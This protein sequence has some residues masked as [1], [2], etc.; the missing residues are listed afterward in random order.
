MERSV[1]DVDADLVEALRRD[2][3]EGAEQLI[4]RYGDRAYRL[5]LRI[6]GVTEDAEA[7]VEAALRT[8]VGAVPTFTGATTFESW[9]VRTV[10]GAAYQTIRRRRQDTNE[11]ALADVVPGLDGDGRHFEPMDDWSTR[12]DEQA[13]QGE[14]GGI[15]TEAI[16]ALP[17]DYRTALILHDAEGV[18]KPD[19][20]AVLGIDVTA[21]PPRV[22]RAR[23]SV[24]RYLSA[25]FA[26]VD[27]APAP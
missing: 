1:A 27:V 25:Y 26:S 19:I 5:A 14:L 9:I 4:E 6:T 8:V 21:V 18:S 12:I 10:A 17:A 22:H 16:D 2:D 3:A 13:L 15:L 11:I 24:R 7:A 20:A 23:L